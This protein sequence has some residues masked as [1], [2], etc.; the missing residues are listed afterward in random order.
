MPK[1]KR[2]KVIA[3]TKTKKKSRDAK[4]K[5][6][7]EI[8]E[9][10]GKYSR[11]FLLSIENER[12]R[13][14]QEI[15]QQLRPGR[16]IIARNKVMQ[17]ALG[18]TASAECQDGIHKLAGMITGQCALLFTDKPPAEVQSFFAEFHPIDFARCG[19][20]ATTTVTLPRGPDTLAKLP[21]SIEAHLRSLGMPTQLREG[22]IHLLG[23][24]TVCKE[25]QELSSDAAQVLKLLDI[26]QAQ[27]A[28]TVEAH[29]H[30][31][32]GKVVDCS[33]LED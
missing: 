8:R 1:S 16:M 11:V 17:L 14:L 28:M 2:N 3:L 32:G 20:V 6:I 26:K 22:K 9:A 12:T 5:L 4:D 13:F 19:A 29:W 30:R 27:F 25:G 33:A 31:D 18:M 24:H 23:D 21:H 15:R 10:C 7:E